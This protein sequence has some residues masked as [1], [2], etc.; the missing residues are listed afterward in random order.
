MSAGAAFRAESVN[1]TATRRIGQLFLIGSALFA[2][3]SIP[4]I[5][6]V[7]L[8]GAAAI[9]FA[10]SIFFTSAAAEQ[11][12]TSE[13]DRLDIWSAAVQLAGTIMF[14]MNTFTALDK[15]LDTRSLD[16][17]VWFPNALGSVCFLICSAMA[18]AAVRRQGLRARR[19]ATLNMLGSIAFGVSAVTAF[20]RPSTHEVI[21]QSVSSWGTLFGAVCFGLAAW[22]LI[23][24]GSRGPREA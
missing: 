20:V 17:L 12:R 9:L 14:N 21:N 6:D 7:T 22:M 2:I 13:S 16:F 15:R 18:C 10:G 19:I 8:P 3:G 1:R 4:A 11:L 24:R 5:R 23:P